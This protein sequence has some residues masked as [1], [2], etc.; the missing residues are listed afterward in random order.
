MNSPVTL[1]SALDH[2]TWPR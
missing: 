2:R 1:N